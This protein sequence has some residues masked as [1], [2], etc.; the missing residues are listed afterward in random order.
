MDCPVH[1][2]LRLVYLVPG[3]IQP[4]TAMLWFRPLLA[5]ALTASDLDS[6][7]PGRPAQ[8]HHQLDSRL[9]TDNI[10]PSR[11]EQ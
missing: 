4:V 11:H 1:P 9:L 10:D 5:S 7:R 6:P 2:R 8:Q 3:L